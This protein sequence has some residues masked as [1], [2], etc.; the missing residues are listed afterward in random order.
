MPF[1]IRIDMKYVFFA[2]FFFSL[3]Y[4]IPTFA[5]F[6]QIIVAGAVLGFLALVL[7]VCVDTMAYLRI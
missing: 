1:T 3:G 7:Y 5:P 4:A 6:L 2:L